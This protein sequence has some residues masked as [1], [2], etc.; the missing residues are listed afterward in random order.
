[1]KQT[2]L[3]FTEYDYTSTICFVG[4]I[5]DICNVNKSN[6]KLSIAVHTGSDDLIYTAYIKRS[7][8]TKQIGNDYTGRFI[9][10][11]GIMGF[12]QAGSYQFD[13]PVSAVVI[14]I[15]KCEYIS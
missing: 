1:M 13:I 5:I 6:I 12:C 8:F 7:V 9:H 4:K 2:K 10:F 3:S 11:N 15:C 14:F